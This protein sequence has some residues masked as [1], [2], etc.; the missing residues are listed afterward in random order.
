MKSQE[1]AAA[2]KASDNYFVIITREDLPNPPYSADEIYGI[3]TSGKYHDRKRT[4]N[5]LYRI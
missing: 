3:Y 1:F 5:E 4:Y 2:V